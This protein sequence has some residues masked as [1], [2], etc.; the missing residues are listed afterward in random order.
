MPQ[1]KPTLSLGQVVLFGLAYMTPIIVL[2]TFGVL[3]TL[4]EGAVSG[5]YIAALVAMLFTALW[6]HAPPRWRARPM[7]MYAM[8][9]TTGWAL[10]PAG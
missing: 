8:P 2:G 1:M 4:T 9:S 3:A 5:A 7:P 6:P 10:S